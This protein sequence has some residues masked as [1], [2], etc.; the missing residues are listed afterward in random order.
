MAQLTYPGVYIE[1][2]APAAPI[3]G[4]GTSTAAFL[5]PAGDGPLM[6]PTKLTSFDALR[7]TFGDP[8]DGFFL[9]YAVR[10]FFENG[11]R[12]CYVVRV[13]NAAYAHVELP[14]A[15][16]AALPTLTVRARVAGTPSPDLK[17]DVDDDAAVTGAALF[18]I[19]AA[20]IQNATGNEIIVTA[21]HAARAAQLRPGDVLTWTGI[22]E[23]TPPVVSRVEGRTIRVVEPL[24]GTYTSGGVRID[25]M[26]ATTT[27]IF[28][29]QTGGDKLAAGSV[30]RISEA[31]GNP[32]TRIVKR[33]DVERVTPALTTYR[34][35]LTQPVS[36]AFTLAGATL[37]SVEFKLTVTQDGYSKAY[38]DLTMSPGHPHYFAD[39]V[40]GDPDRRVEVSHADPPSTSAAPDN[41]PAATAAAQT[42]TGGAVDNPAGLVASDYRAALELLRPVDDV[43]MVAIPDRTDPDVQGAVRDHCEAMMDRFAILDSMRGAPLF[44]GGSVEVQRNGLTS[45]R[46]Y[47]ALYYPWLLVP[48]AAG[49]HNLLVP[50]SGHIAGVYAR[51]D[52]LRGVHKAP[53]GEEATLRGVVAIEST[54]S[55]TDQGE[56]N[57]AGINVVRVFRPG[58]RPVVWGARTT[59]SDRNWQYVN[60]RRLFLFLEESIQE[61]INWA[62]FEP[63]NLS[64]WQG[65]RRSIGDFLT[66][67]WRDGALFGATAEEAFYTRIDDVINPFSEQ[68]LGRLHIEIGVRPTYPAEFIVVR[69]GIW[70]GGSEITEG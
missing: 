9:W 43:N 7:E 30:V 4:V 59:A 21:A 35:E 5:G 13:S 14:D 67:A 60:I 17:V 66:A 31:G 23:T 54:M 18:Q 16:A 28:R 20:T 47:A 11:G 58:G 15:S 3:Q 12:V 41:R 62:V 26:V 40:A 38:E 25:D 46:G 48:P 42:L 53:A 50:P 63:N 27:R 65:L 8:L 33:V 56:L 34:V 32:D 51:I 52:E 61:G 44:G 69:I 10:G 24:S 68:Q 6:E 49:S 64:L 37:A 1:E 19:S 2:F 57:L 70:Q 29:L 39:V 22:A 55:D 36:R 45:A